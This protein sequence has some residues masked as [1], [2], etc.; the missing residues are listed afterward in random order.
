MVKKSDRQEAFIEFLMTYGWAILV[1]I[2]GIGALWYFGV[3]SP[4][5]LLPKNMQIDKLCETECEM[6]QW[7]YSGTYKENDDG[8]YNCDCHEPFR[9]MIVVN[10]SEL[11]IEQTNGVNQT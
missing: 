2:A 6:N 1:M 11:D 10:S 4:D 9:V 7:I 3:L 5:N 8:S